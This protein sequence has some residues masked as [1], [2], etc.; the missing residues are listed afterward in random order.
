MIELQNKIKEFMDDINKNNIKY[1]NSTI[2]VF[3]NSKNNTDKAY[4]LLKPFLNENNFSVIKTRWD[5]FSSNNKCKINLY[6]VKDYMLGLKFKYII[7]DTSIRNPFVEHII[8]PAYIGSTGENMV[9]IDCFKEFC[10][11]D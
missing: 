10:M 7:Y 9:C 4:N 8:A 5:Y 1:S 11:E 2:A 6:T 3:F